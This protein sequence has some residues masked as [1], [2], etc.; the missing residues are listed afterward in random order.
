MDRL[1]S[2]RGADAVWFPPGDEIV[3]DDQFPDADQIA[4]AN[5]PEHIE[6]HR[7]SLRADDDVAATSG[8][9]RHELGHARQ[10]EAL[11]R[12]IFNLQRFI[13]EALA[14]RA[15]GLDG[16]AGHLIN[17][18]PTELDTNAAASVLLRERHPREVE[19]ILTIAL[20][21]APGSSKDPCRHHPLNAGLAG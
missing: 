1:G 12:S 10:Y 17:A 13:E 6:L 3:V 11:G 16:C 15:G 9:M 5:A 7:M 14:Y 4:D 18:I 2:E 8:R 21:V 20:G 19:R